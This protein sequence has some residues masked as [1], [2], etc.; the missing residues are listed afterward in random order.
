M[1]EKYQTNGALLVGP[2]V[3][4]GGIVTGEQLGVMP[5]NRERFLALAKMYRLRSHQDS[6]F[7][8]GARHRSQIWEFGVAKLGLTVTGSQFIRKCRSEADWLTAKS[9]GDQEANF[10]CAWTDENLA[11]LE[12]LA[13]LQKRKTSV[14][15]VGSGQI[16]DTPDAERP[17]SEGL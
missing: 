4:F 13:G 6:W 2:V 3:P 9:I 11:N 1:N 8:D 5:E 16:S 7:V 14:P 17:F 15:S 12:A 10:Y